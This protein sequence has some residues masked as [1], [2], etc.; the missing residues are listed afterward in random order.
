MQIVDINNAQNQL[1][2]L[3]KS[4]VSGND[5]LI[6]TG[7]GAVVRLTPVAKADAVRVGGQWKGKIKISEDFD[8]CDKEI[9]ELF[10]NSKL[11]PDEDVK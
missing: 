7:S 6:S 11:F 9:E 5:V 1:A 2:A 10:Y 8:K 3:I 4:A